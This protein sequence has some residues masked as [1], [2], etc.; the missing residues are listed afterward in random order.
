MT[1]PLHGIRVVEVG[2]F[3]AVPYATALLA[4]LGAE[5]VKVE[6]FPLGDPFRRGLDAADPYFAQ[7]NA[8]KKSLAL[9]LKADAGRRVLDSLL[10]SSDAFIHNLRPGKAEALGFGSD[11]LSERYRHLVHAAVSGFGDTGPMVQRPGYDS[12]AQSVSGLYSVL[13][14]EGEAQ[15]PGLP[16]AD[17]TTGITSAIGICAQLARRAREGR[18]GSLGTS[19][20]EVAAMLSTENLA[21]ATP[22]HSQRSLPQSVRSH[23]Y[24]VTCGD[25]VV[26]LVSLG[27]ADSPWEGLRRLAMDSGADTGRKVIEVVDQ[28]CIDRAS[29]RR[30]VAAWLDDHL[31]RLDSENALAQLRDHGIPAAPAR[32]YGAAIEADADYAARIV[33]DFPDMA[34]DLV[35]PGVTFDGILPARIPHVARVGE[36]TLELLEELG[37]GDDAHRLVNEGVVHIPG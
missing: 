36:Q 32:S 23:T 34:I 8:G 15:A 28:P 5:V 29:G 20:L 25:G 22:S 17:L 37:W 3:M 9:D 31:S 21:Y 35:R 13:A 26:V 10:G 14:P 12:A 30:L 7:Y 4:G 1:A 16:L 11:Q 2:S 24:T 33:Q 6:P 19:L 27:T 18:G